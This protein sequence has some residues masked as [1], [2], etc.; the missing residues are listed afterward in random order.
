MYVDDFKLADKAENIDSTWQ[1]LMEYVDQRD[2]TLFLDHVY[3]GCTQ[4]ECKISSEIVTNFRDIFEFRISAG[5]KE[6]LPTRASVKLDAETLSSCSYD[7]E[8][9]AK[10]CVERYYELANKTTQQ[11]Y[12][13][14]TPCMDVHQFEEENE[15]VGELSKVCSQIVLKCLYLYRIDRLDMLWSRNKLTRAVI[16][17]TKSCDKHLT[18]LISYIHHTSEYQQYW[19]V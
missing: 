16:N 8:G 19:Y 17:W 11:L 10:K 12:K 2:S 13:V 6:K 1:T 3:F 14:V 9:H 7:M 15:S 18:R 4:R 5:V